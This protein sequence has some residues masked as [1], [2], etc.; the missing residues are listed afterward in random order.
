MAFFLKISREKRPSVKAGEML[1]IWTE[2]EV[3][4]FFRYRRNVNRIFVGPAKPIGYW[5]Q[6]QTF[7][8]EFAAAKGFAYKSAGLDGSIA[9]GYKSCIFEGF[10]SQFTAI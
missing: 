5:V 1:V 9:L 8:C 3:Q 10:L 4:A 6:E 7:I 2:K